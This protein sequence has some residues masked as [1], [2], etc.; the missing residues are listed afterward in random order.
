MKGRRL[1]RLTNAAFKLN[2]FT[3]FRERSAKIYGLRKPAKFF[4]WLNCRPSCCIQ[5]VSPPSLQ[6]MP[7]QLLNLSMK[8]QNFP[9]E[10]TRPIR[11]NRVRVRVRKVPRV[12]APHPS[13]P[14]AAPLASGRRAPRAD[15]INLL[16]PTQL[17]SGQTLGYKKISRS[18]QLIAKNLHPRYSPKP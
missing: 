13:R 9:R 8:I 7:P 3:G 18:F 10:H 15:A 1:N 16:S 17:A 6:G 12:R 5:P 11:Q 14:G 2:R 4:K